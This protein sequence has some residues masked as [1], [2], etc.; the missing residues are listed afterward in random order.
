MMNLK[1]DENVEF[2]YQS[3]NKWGI[4]MGCIGHFFETKRTGCHL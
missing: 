1:I 2:Q 3:V 4:G